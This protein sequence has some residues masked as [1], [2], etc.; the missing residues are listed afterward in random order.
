M[1]LP[2]PYYARRGWH[3]LVSRSGDGDVSQ[4]LLRGF[5]YEVIR[6]SSS[7]GGARALRDM[8]AV[9]DA[10]SVLIIT[11]DGPRG[12][13]HSMNQGLAWMARATGYPVIPCGLVCD[14]AWRSKSWDRFTIPKLRARVVFVYGAPIWVGRSASEEDLRQTTERIGVEMT[15]AEQRGFELLGL[16]PD[17]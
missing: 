2:L 10:G 17:W 16:E 8:L 7:R 6:G 15:R 13:R 14:R 5:G 4:E 11:P 12:P 1:I 9:L 3:V